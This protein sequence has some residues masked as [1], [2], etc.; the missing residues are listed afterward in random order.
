MPLNAPSWEQLVRRFDSDATFERPATPIQLR[1]VE[2]ALRVHQPAELEEVL[3]EA[4][5]ITGDY[6]SGVIWSVGEIEQRNRQ[7]RTSLDFRD[8]Y[9]P[10]DHLLFFGDDGAGDQFAFAIHADGRIHKQDV[11]R[12]EHET[13]SR[14]WFAGR[15]EQF[16]ERRLAQ[17]REK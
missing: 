3:L 1:S 5:G 11:Y 8:L 12:W 6:G 14:F 16:F 13:D 2:Q 17:D 9:M 10:F 4:D 15:L 7:F